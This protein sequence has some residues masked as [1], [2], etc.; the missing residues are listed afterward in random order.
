MINTIIELVKMQQENINKLVD[1]TTEQK[2][3]GEIPQIKKVKKVKSVDLEEKTPDES[4]PLGMNYQEFTKANRQAK[5][6]RGS[7][8]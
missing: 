7:T 6:Q 3:T 1:L 4:L 2:I 5:L 8:K